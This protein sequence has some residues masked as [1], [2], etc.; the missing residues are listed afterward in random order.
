MLERLLN[1]PLILVLMGI[2]S[3]AMLVPA[4]HALTLEDHS[5]ARGFFYS[6]LLSLSIIIMISISLSGRPRSENH[7]IEN[8]ASL[9]LAYTAMPVILA[10][11]FY[12]G[13]ETTRFLNAYVAMVSALTT[14]GATL[15][16]DPDRWV[17]SLHL[18]RALVA[19]LGGFMI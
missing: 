6:R 17:D 13:L 14:T 10:I 8:L 1:L 4:L 2:F 3:I 15:F 12:E 18:W 11:P 5:V 9:A 19:G 16:T 7:D